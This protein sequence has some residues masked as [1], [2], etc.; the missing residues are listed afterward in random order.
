MFSSCLKAGGK[1]RNIELIDPVLGLSVTKGVSIGVKPF[2][3]SRASIRNF[4]KLGS[5]MYDL[6]NKVAGSSLS[7]LMS[8][9]GRQG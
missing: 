8:S 4:S 7:F 6:S 1:M 9:S 2:A 5:R 3:L